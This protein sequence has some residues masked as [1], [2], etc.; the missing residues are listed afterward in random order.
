CDTKSKRRRCERRSDPV[1]V[2]FGGDRRNDAA[3]IEVVFAL[4]HVPFPPEAWTGA[5]D[6][7]S[8]TIMLD[9]SAKLRRRF[10]P[11][12]TASGSRHPCSGPVRRCRFGSPGASVYPLRPERPPRVTSQRRSTKFCIWAG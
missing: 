2:L 3:A 11:D 12:P 7:S 9:D 4:G 10:E 6:R 1:Q 5:V 8:E